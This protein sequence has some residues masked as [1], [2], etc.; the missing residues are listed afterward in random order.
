MESHVLNSEL[1]YSRY[2]VTVALPFPFFSYPNRVRHRFLRRHEVKTAESTPDGIQFALRSLNDNHENTETYDAVI[3]A[4]GYQRTHYE[5]LLVP[6]MP[7]FE[8]FSVDRYYRLCHSMQFKPAI[9]L[10]GACE[11]SHGLSDTLL[12]VTAIR[13][14]EI[15]HAMINALHQA[16]SPPS[17]RIASSV[18]A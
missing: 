17:K 7:Y 2:R 3:L 11:S 15:A 14:S 18:L 10:Q 12:S 6:L 5:T 13:T 4:T 1:A 8:D 16:K 9:F